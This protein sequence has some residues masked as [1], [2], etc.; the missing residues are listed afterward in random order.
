MVAKASLSFNFTLETYNRVS[1]KKRFYLRYGKILFPEIFRSGGECCYCLT[2]KHFLF[3][4]FIFP[5]KVNL[6]FM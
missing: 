3:V 5:R 4:K 1:Q 2:A 6:K